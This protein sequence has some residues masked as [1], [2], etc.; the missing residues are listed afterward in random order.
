MGSD[1]IHC[2]EEFE[3]DISTSKMYGEFP[4]ICRWFHDNYSTSKHLWMLY[5]IPISLQAKKIGEI[6]FGRSTIVLAD[7]AKHL[8]IK[9]IVCDRYD[10][11]R[12]VEHLPVLYIKGY[13]DDFYNHKEVKNGG[14]DFIFIDYLS[15]RKSDAL[16]CYKEIKKAFKVLKQNGFLAIHDTDVSKYNV[17]GA[18]T[19][20][21][22]KHFEDAEIITFPYCYGMTLI[23]KTAKSEFGK[24]SIV[25]LKKK[26]NHGD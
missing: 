19:R 22:K 17:K 8:G 25:S 20:F 23:R 7:V 1:R 9:H 18:V 14:M 2:Q 5:S 11:R 21:R 13:S 3:S 24:I 26:D 12:Y 4:F 15:S 16:S 10:Y 6:G